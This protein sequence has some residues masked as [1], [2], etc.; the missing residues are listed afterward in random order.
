MDDLINMFLNY[1]VGD[2]GGV[3]GGAYLK[4]AFLHT[5]FRP[6]YMGIDSFTLS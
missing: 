5:V 3:G 1:S 6:L 2:N 4:T